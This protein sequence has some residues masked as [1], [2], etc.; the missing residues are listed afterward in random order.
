VERVNLRRKPK[1]TY[2]LAVLDR[3]GLPRPE[4]I[5]SEPVEVAILPE[6]QLRVAD[7]NLDL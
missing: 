7:A 3:S 4:S 1:A 2:F 6:H 5:A